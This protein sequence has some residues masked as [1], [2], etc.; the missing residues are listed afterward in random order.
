M[1]AVI[2]IPETSAFSSHDE[3]PKRS[4]ILVLIIQSLRFHQPDL[5]LLLDTMSGKPDIILL[6]ETWL[7]ENEPIDKLN[8]KKAINLSNQN[9]ELILNEGRAV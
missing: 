7:S 4:T 8:I 3:A 5:A 9:L 2:E 6:M 1:E